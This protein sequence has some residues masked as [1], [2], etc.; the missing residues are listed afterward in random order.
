MGIPTV[1][2]SHNVSVYTTVG[3]AISVY[4]RFYEH[5]NKY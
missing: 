2:W 4:S 1:Q 3:F 5:G